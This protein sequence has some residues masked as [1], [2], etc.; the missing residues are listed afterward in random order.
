M[1][2]VKLSIKPEDIQKNPNFS[3]S[4]QATSKILQIKEPIKA[5]YIIVSLPNETAGSCLLAKA[6]LTTQAKTNLLLE[7]MAKLEI[8]FK[9]LQQYGNLEASNIGVKANGQ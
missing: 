4:I 9:L 5:A 8:P 3:L 7:M 6:P 2:N 1:K